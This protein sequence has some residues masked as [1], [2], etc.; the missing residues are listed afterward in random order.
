MMIFKIAYNDD[1]EFLVKKLQEVIP[2]KYTFIKLESYQEEVF[3]ERKKAFKLK[4]SY[5][6]R[7][8]PFAVLIDNDNV[9]VH[10][11]YTESGDCTF[12]NIINTLN[13]YVPYGCQDNNRN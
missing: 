10:A 9:V 6:A 1:S 3:K 8:S 5:S 12:E 13:E 2:S 11:F 7:K 4:G